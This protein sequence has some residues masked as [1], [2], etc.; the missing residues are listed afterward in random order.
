MQCF[1]EHKTCLRHRTFKG[2]Y[3][4]NATIGHVEHTLYFTPEVGVTWSVDD[5]DFCILVVN[6]NVLRKNG[7]TTFT[8]EVVII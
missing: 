8:F 7:D 1:L 4:E 5:I 6:R 2:I 3:E